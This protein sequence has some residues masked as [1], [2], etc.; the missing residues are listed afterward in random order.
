MRLRFFAFIFFS[1][2]SAACLSNAETLSFSVVPEEIHPGKA[3]RIVL[4]V[5][6]DD[7][8]DIGVCSEG[9]DTYLHVL[10]EGLSVPT[11]TLSFTFDGYVA[12]EAL[13][14]GAY[15]LTA[16]TAT[17][18]ASSPVKIGTPAPRIITA[19]AQPFY[20]RDSLS[21]QLNISFSC[22]ATLSA[23]LIDPEGSAIPLGSFPVTESSQKLVFEKI[24]ISIAGDHTL[25]LTVTD[26]KG[27]SGNSFQLVIALQPPATP[28]PHPTV[29]PSSDATQTKPGDYWTM[30]VGNYDWNAIWQVMISPMTIVKGSGKQAE[31]QTYKLRKAPDPSS[32][33]E[34]VCG[35]I[36]C[37][38][39]GIHVI[40]T[41]E[42]GW[43]Y[44]EVFN[45][46]YGEEYRN[47][48]KGTG[49]GTTDDLVRGYVETSRLDTFIPRTEYGLLIDKLTQN[50]YIVTEKGLLATL[51]V[52]T[53]TPTNKQ[54]WNETPSGEFYLSSKVGDFPSGNLIC[55][56][57]MRFNNGDILHQ[58]PY[59]YNEK[60]DIPDY[61]SCE[62]YLGQK[63]SHGCVRVQRK[64][65]EDGYN[66]KWIWD[67]VPIRTKLLIWD[68]DGRPPL[69][70]DYPF[71]PET[72]LYYNPDGGQ[73][74]HTDRN[75]SSIKNRFLPLKGTVLYKDLDLPQYSYLTPC[76]SCSKGILRV[77]EIDKANHENGY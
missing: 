48:G 41:F 3:E 37:E 7:A 77:S 2:L 75:C 40:E 68:D 9:G 35:L 10:R 50:L 38:T 13:P 19:T 26:D 51:L 11:G 57:G 65:G 52:S 23:L 73:Y 43:S 70:I 1:L 66:M 21:L 39:Q 71:D 59:I 44:V 46:S 8:L 6:S 63:A 72:V 36:T 49:F 69:Y 28:K 55:Q 14:E 56:Y 18:S 29:R 45:S 24:K 67:N 31:R 27:I 74:Y 30:E 4:S 12:G 58:V 22:P 32:A 16:R 76:N 53:G 60:Y 5:P 64:A 42:T 33:A 15:L 34:N 20:S 17:Q 54:P 61:S 47:T 62:K 25:S